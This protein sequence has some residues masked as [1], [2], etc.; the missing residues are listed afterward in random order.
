MKRKLNIGILSNSTL[1]KDALKIMLEHFNNLNSIDY[2][3][4]RNLKKDFENLDVLLSE[5]EFQY[6]ENFT[7]NNSLYK[8]NKDL[9][10][11]IIGKEKINNL[12]DKDIYLVKPF[13]FLELV[14]IFDKLYYQFLT[15]NHHEAKWGE[16]TFSLSNKVL[17]YYGRTS[18]VLTDKE[19][20]IMMALM[21]RKYK[22][23]N[24]EQVLYDIWGFNKNIATHTFETHLY[25]LRRKIKNKL[26]IDDLIINKNGNYFLNS[27]L[28]DKSF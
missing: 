2:I 1:F 11:I 22:G 15:E 7:K 10:R 9:R 12:S 17:C 4:I 26:M 14:N 27:Y 25:R 23:I 13:R 19:S 21:E 28:L 16:L 3:V 18:V 8:L 20:D 5:G 24:K 6:I